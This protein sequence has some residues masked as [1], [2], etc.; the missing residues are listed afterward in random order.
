MSLVELG[1]LNHLTVSVSRVY[2]IYLKLRSEEML[3]LKIINWTI[4]FILNSCA[5]K[6]S[7]QMYEF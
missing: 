3:M 4:L 5:V 6:V 7:V 1:F 2:L